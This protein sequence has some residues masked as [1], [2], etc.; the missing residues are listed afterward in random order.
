MVLSELDP[1]GFTL[2]VGEARCTLTSDNAS[3]EIEL[4]LAP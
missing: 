1:E 3:A 2:L 4:V